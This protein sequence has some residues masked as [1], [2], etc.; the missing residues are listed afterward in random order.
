MLNAWEYSLSSGVIA[1]KPNRGW[2]TSKY[3]NAQRTG[4]MI[5]TTN[6]THVYMFVSHQD[7]P[8]TSDLFNEL[9]LL[10]EPVVGTMEHHS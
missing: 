6:T 8:M 3:K 9:M 1:S 5:M 4:K 7:K 2:L 10:M